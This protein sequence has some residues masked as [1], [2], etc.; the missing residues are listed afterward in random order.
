MS[1]KSIFR[2]YACDIEEE[3]RTQQEKNLNMLRLSV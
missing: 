1:I 2:Q 3:K